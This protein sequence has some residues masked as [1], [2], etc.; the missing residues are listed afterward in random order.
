MVNEVETLSRYLSL[1]LK[2]AIRPELTRIFCVFIA[3]DTSI[4][5]YYC[6]LIRFVPS[7]EEREREREGR[8]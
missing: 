6:S 4:I 3:L 8:R 2:C 5:K 1:M 7:G